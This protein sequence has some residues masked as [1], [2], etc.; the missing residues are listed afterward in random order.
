MEL[1]SNSVLVFSFQFNS[2]DV[3]DH[4]L[5]SFYK[6]LS[7]NFMFPSKTEHEGKEICS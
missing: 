3:N 4:I 6:I 7:S 5:L 2:C 1:A